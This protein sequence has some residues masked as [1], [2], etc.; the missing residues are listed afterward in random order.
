MKIERTSI[1]RAIHDLALVVVEINTLA[2]AS[3]DDEQRD[4]L[5]WILVNVTDTIEA[6]ATLED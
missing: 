3:T 6:I 1:A 5:N 2:L 4:K